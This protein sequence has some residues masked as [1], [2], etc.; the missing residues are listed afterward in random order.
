MTRAVDVAEDGVDGLGIAG[1]AG[2][3][4]AFV[5]P[6]D[7]QV[8]IEFIPIVH[9]CV[10]NERLDRR[11]LLDLPVGE[12]IGRGLETLARFGLI[13]VKA[14]LG[15]NDVALAAIVEQVGLVEIARQNLQVTEGNARRFE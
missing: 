3:V 4:G 15:E 8:E 5:A 12:R 11:L 14:L 1:R 13:R 2:Q 7:A 10:E 6:A 9:V